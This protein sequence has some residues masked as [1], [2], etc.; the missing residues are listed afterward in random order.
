MRAAIYER[1]GGPEV[2]KLAEVPK[3]SPKDTELLIKIHTTTVNS[4][5][6]RLRSLRVP[7]GLGLPTR[8]SLGL[9]GPR[10]PI[11]GME[12]AGEVEAVGSAVT[13]FKPGDR[14]IGSD[15]FTLGCHAEYKCIPEDAALADI[16]AKLTY[17]DAVSLCFGGSTAASFFSRG[18]LRIGET[19]LINGASGAVGAAAVQ[20]AKHLGA[21]VTGVCSTDNLALVSSLGA[22]HV[23][24]YTKDDFTKSG[25]TYDVIME[26]V[27]NAPF[28]RV[29]G[30]LKPDGRFLMVY[31]NLPQMIGAG[32]HKQVTGGVANPTEQV[33]GEPAFG[34]LMKLA[35]AGALKPVIDRTYPLEEIAA[36]HAYVDSGRKKGT[37]VITV[38]H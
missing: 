8:L 3:P 4:G 21:E 18:G 12:L 22:D 9:F 5:D 19:V 35:A 1:Y 26:T 25:V 38:A 33:F 32:M 37:V 16:P 17:A 28:A 31:G 24:D 10:Q 36:A 20:I 30:A 23:I 15:G 11:L 34:Y 29:N 2:V 14:V 6:V 13:K 7:R 27:G